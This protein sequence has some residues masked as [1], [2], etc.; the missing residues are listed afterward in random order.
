VHRFDVRTEL[1]I[2]DA[3]AE[4][5]RELATPAAEMLILGAPDPADLER[6]FGDLLG[7]TL[8]EPA[9]IV[10]S[11]GVAHPRVAHAG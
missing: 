7:A 2:G 11:S 6:R 1:R 8:N 3:A 9:L 10:G 5:A 4:L